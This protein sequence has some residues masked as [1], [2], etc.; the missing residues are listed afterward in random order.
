MREV[1][2]TFAKGCESRVPLYGCS[3]S[4]GTTGD[5]AAVAA[6]AGRGVVSTEEQIPRHF[7]VKAATTSL[8]CNQL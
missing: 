4:L 3:A 2:G 7:L 6:V 1:L 5:T 8:G